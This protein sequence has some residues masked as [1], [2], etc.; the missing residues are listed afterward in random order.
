[1]NQL[2]VP[3]PMI[4]ELYAGFV[5]PLDP[6][7]L[8]PRQNA[9]LKALVAGLLLVWLAVFAFVPS[10]PASGAPPLTTA[11]AVK[12]LADADKNASALPDSRLEQ[13]LAKERLQ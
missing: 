8:S 10:A 4:E 12:E 11:C 13:E 3:I 7:L 2:C 5:P 1:M 6:A 9:S